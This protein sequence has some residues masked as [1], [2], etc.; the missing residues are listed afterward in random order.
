MAR[1]RP[2]AFFNLGASSRGAFSSFFLSARV[3]CARVHPIKV[4]VLGIG[5]GFAVGASSLTIGNCFSG[6]RTTLP[7]RRLALAASIPIGDNDDLPAQAPQKKKPPT[8][9]SVSDDGLCALAFSSNKAEIVRAVSGST[10]GGDKHSSHVAVNL[11][12]K[13][14]V[15]PLMVAAYRGDVAM[16]RLLLDHGA[17]PDLRSTLKPHSANDEAIRRDKSISKAD[18]QKLLSLVQSVEAFDLSLWR[19]YFSPFSPP[20]AGITATEFAVLGGNSDV[21]Q[22]LVERS[23]TANSDEHGGLAAPQ[24]QSPHSRS[25]YDLVDMSP[26]VKGTEG[27]IN[28]ARRQ[29]L[30][31]AI[32][33]GFERREELRRQRRAQFPLE[34]RL[35]ESLVGQRHAIHVVSSAIRRKE[36]GWTDT[37]SPLVL[38]FMGSSG[39]GKTETSKLIAKYL[40]QGD[41]ATLQKCFIRLDMT[42]YQ[43]K[44]EVSKFIGS[45]PGYVGYDEGGQLVKK[46]GACP[47]AVVLLDEVEKAHPDAL[48]VLM[49]AFDEGRLTDGHGRT[50]DCK[51]AVF[52]MTSNMAQTEIADEAVRL[53]ET[54]AIADKHLKSMS[55]DAGCDAVGEDGL[56]KRFK[57]DVVQPI[58]KRH[59]G[60][61]EFLGRINEIVFFLPFTAEEQ[62]QLAEKELQLWAARARN[63]HDIALTW[64]RQIPSMVASAYDIRYGARSIKYE[65]DRTCVAP[66]ARA[67]ELG[68]LSKGCSVHIAPSHAP[69]SA[70]TS[71][72]EGSIRVEVHP[73]RRAQPSLLQKVFGGATSKQHPQKE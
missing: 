69:S 39:I 43:T 1:F 28:E 36:N 55:R 61:D 33:L 58:L 19:T 21:V 10:G 41:A 49:Q 46:L 8:K 11:F 32:E 70:A 2:S 40:F 73:A 15:T 63:R 30:R 12:G 17:D 54:A 67:H 60:R 7:E 26:Q 72:V 51:E 50:V 20:N 57:K 38:L 53:R 34:S 23:T 59:F 24:A 65:I 14:G 68:L 29:G 56:T 37:D 66:I 47:N 71:H 3:W 9:D 6:R 27:S 16:V 31:R 35:S 44:H 25:L 64:D 42:E 4:G 18:T 13:A 22:L 45:P 48:T 5:L 62:Q 52:V